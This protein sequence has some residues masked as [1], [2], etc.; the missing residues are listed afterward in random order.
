MAG[1]TGFELLGIMWKVHMCLHFSG[2]RVYTFRPISNVFMT[3]TKVQSFS[4]HF[5]VRCG[6]QQSD[7]VLSAPNEVIGHGKRNLDFAVLSCL[8]LLTTY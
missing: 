3:Q 1:V 7:Q 8:L 4:S 2:K 5:G 6:G